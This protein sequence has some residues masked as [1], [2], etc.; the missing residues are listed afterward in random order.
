M[1][2]S[3]KRNTQLLSVD[4][5]RGLATSKEII[6]TKANMKDVSLDN[7]KT[8]EPGQIA[9]VSDTSRRAD[10]I[11]LGF[12][13][14]D[15]TYLVSSISTVFGTQEDRLLPKYLMLF[16]TRSEFDRYARFK[17]WGSARETFDFGEMCR[18]RIP[19]P[20]IKIQESI[21]EI[22]TVYRKRIE[23]NEKLKAQIKDICPI[24][25]KGAIEEARKLK[26]A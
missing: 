7:Y 10:K 17:S 5:V 6:P 18:V 22:Y 15:D 2:E 1:I 9:Y 23:I 8:L 16:L 19:V 20:D 12:N 3:N 11:S 13:D 24:L 4:C 21:A 14:T 25:I 26:E